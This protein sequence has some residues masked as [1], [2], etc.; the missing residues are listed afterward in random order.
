MRFSLREGRNG[1]FWAAGPIC[2]QFPL[3]FNTLAGL[4][5]G[6]C[7]S[8]LKA[9]KKKE[10]CMEEQVKELDAAGQADAE[11]LLTLGTWL[12]RRQALG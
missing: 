9:C 7:P 5:L 10:G 3:F 1:L 4:E 8:D 2:R 11:G 6:L 12:G